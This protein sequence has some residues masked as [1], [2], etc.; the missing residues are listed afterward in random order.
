MAGG[1]AQQGQSDNSMGFIWII[2]AVFAFL[3][4][5]WLTFKTQIVGAYFQVKLFEINLLGHFTHKLDDVRTVIQTTDPSQF[6]FQDVINVGRMVGDYLRLPFAAIILVLAVLVYTNNSTR[7]FKRIYTMKDLV[8]LERFNWPQITPVANLNLTKTDIDKGPWAMALTPM[9]FGKKYKLLEEFK[10]APGEGVSKKE[11]NKIEVKLKRGMANKI[12]AM[13]I[14]PLWQ[15]TDKLPMHIRA[16]FAAFAARYNSDSKS[17][18]ELLGRI[19]ASSIK[20]L[21]FTGTDELLKKHISTKGIQKIMHGHAYVLTV[22]ASMLV[23]A[24]EDGVQASA[25]FLWLKP[26]DRRLWY[27]LNTVGRQTPFVEVAGPYAHWL[28]EKEIGRPLIVPM[29]EEATNALDIALQEIIY[30]PDEE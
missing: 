16:L 18:G 15:G 27:M 14:G 7:V 29:V 21:D 9:Q 20:K 22:M 6:K 1:G 10:K 17:A 5:I 4:I 30:K 12:F 23:G 25:D 11:W 26:V 19:S 28:A 24:R 2:A 3:A 13:Q 8:Q